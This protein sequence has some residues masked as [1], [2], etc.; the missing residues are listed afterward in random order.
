MCG[1]F[2]LFIPLAEIAKEFQ[3]E[4]LS[5]GFEPDYNISP[6]RNVPL[7]IRDTDN[8]LILSRWGFVPVWADDLAI[9]NRMINARAETVADKPMFKKAVAEQRCIVPANGFYEWR[10]IGSRKQP[11]YISRKDGKIMAL[12]G[13]HN[14][15]VSPA[16][17]KVNTFAIITTQPNELVKEIHNRMPV[18]LSKEQY[19]EWLQTGK[20]SPEALERLFKPFPSAKL[21]SHDVSSKVNSPANNAPDN[22]DP[23][24]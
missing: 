24:D 9:G 1:R 3:A 13:I 19:E 23:L 7:V 4:Q 11:V 8:R 21:E 17:E 6:S 15:W 14:T 18:I 5:F 20:L 22:I 12:A 10:K 2:V 16:G